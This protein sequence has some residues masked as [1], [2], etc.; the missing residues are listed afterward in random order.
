MPYNIGSRGSNGCS[1]Y[2]VL[3]ED[4]EIMG[5]HNTRSEAE[6]Q[7]R[8]LYASEEM[9]KSYHSEDEEMDKWDNVTKS[10]WV[11][12]KQEGMKEKDGRM[13]PNCVPVGKSE[14]KSMNE[15]EFDDIDEYMSKWNGVFSPVITKKKHWDDIIKPRKG[16]PSNKELYNRIK[17]EAKRKFDVYPSAVANS[18]V[19]AEYKRR[20]GTYK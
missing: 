7:Q 19:V 13:V 3:K 4:G 18:W 9:D 11:G 15:D 10:C 5:C 16:E 14:N 8:A 1:G 17:A 20:G 2:P 12:Y 6:A